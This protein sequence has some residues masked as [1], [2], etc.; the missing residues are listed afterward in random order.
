MATGGWRGRRVV[1]DDYEA[2][3]CLVAGCQR[4]EELKGGRPSGGGL[5]SGHRY[6][7]QRG[8]PLEPPLHDGL[9]RRLS[10]RRALIEAAMALGEVDTA[11]SADVLFRRAVDRLTHAAARYAQARRGAGARKAPGSR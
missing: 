2:R 6:R 7:K 1:T 10:P 11:A 4:L 9:A 8:L 5:C 3:E